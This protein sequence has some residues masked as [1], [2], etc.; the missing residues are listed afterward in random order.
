MSPIAS[1]SPTSWIIA[2]FL[3][4]SCFDIT[5][6]LKGLR[7]SGHHPIFSCGLLLH[8]GLSC[9]RPPLSLTSLSPL[10]QALHGD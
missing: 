10:D 9:F 6:I 8:G 3:S 4:I 1:V 2:L 7:M 5:P